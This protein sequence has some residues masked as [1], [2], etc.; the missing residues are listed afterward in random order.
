MRP[1]L[2]VNASIGYYAGPWV[3]TEMVRRGASNIGSHAAILKLCFTLLEDH[4]AGFMFEDALRESQ[5]SLEQV[6]FNNLRARLKVVLAAFFVR[7][8]AFPSPLPVS[9]SASTAKASS[10]PWD[11]TVGI[12]RG[13]NDNGGAARS[14]SHGHLIV[15]IGQNPLPPQRYAGFG[16][17]GSGSPTYSRSRILRSS[18]GKRGSPRKES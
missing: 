10:G 17:A 1:K 7:E 13:G 9:I 14:P 6:I 18:A 3:E 8:P 2:A 4:H 16:T 5:K 12:F 15:E 11:A